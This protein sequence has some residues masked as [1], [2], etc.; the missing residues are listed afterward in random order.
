MVQDTGI[1]IAEEDIPKLF[2]R[3][4]KLQ[5]TALINSEGIGLGLNIVKQIVEMCSGAINAYSEGIGH[6]STFCFSMLMKEKNPRIRRDRRDFQS[7]K[8]MP[9]QSF[10]SS[11]ESCISMNSVNPSDFTLTN[12]DVEERFHYPYENFLKDRARIPSQEEAQR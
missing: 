5:R 11:Y 7:S 9:Q 3:F 10:I 8:N 12:F 6:G 1:G 2:T 4:G